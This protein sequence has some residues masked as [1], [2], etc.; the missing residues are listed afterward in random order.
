VAQLILNL[1]KYLSLTFHVINVSANRHVRLY[2]F[3][4]SIFLFLFVFCNNVSF[5]QKIKINSS[6]ISLAEIIATVEQQ[7]DYNF[8]Y[9]PDR[10]PLSEKI[11]LVYP[12]YDIKDLMK[13][14][15]TSLEIDYR[16][17]SRKRI[18]LL[19]K[20][21]LAT[22]EGTANKLFSGIVLDA[23]SGEPLLGA[24]ITNLDR[25]RG[26]NTNEIGLFRYEGLPGED[27][28]MISFIG[29]SHR[30]IGSNQL[31]ESIQ[32]ISLHPN[33]EFEEILIRTPNARKLESEAA[34]NFYLNQNQL[35][36]GFGFL[37]TDP[38]NKVMQLSGIHSGREGQKSIYVRGGSADQNLM[39]MDGV[40]LYETSHVFGLSSIFNINAIK[41]VQVFKHAYPA[42]YGGRLSSIIDFR[43]NEG[44]VFERNSSIGISPI[45][46]HF[47][48]EGPIVKGKS[49]YNLSARKSMV[50]VF[51]QEPIENLLDFD[52]SDFN[53]YDINL[54]L[55][56]EIV[57]GSKISFNYYRGRDNL[58]IFQ[59]DLSNSADM[60]LERNSFDKLRWGNNI[61][62]LN[63]HHNVN[64]RTFSKISIS[65]SDYTYQARSAFQFANQSSQTSEINS[66]D[67]LAN[68]RI[69]DFGANAEFQFFVNNKTELSF[70]TGVYHHR[71]NPTLKQSQIY[72]DGSL[73]EFANSAP[74]I[75]ADEIYV[76]GDGKFALGESTT[77]QTGLRLNTFYVRETNYVSLQPRLTLIQEVNKR[78]KL[79]LS[80][81]KMTQFVHLLVNPGIGLPTEL[82]IPSTDRLP[83]ENAY[84]FAVAYGGFLS[85]NFSFEIGAYIKR[86]ENV[87]EYTSPFDLFYTFLNYS[88]IEI[89]FDTNRDWENFVQ[90]GTSNSRGLE[91]SLSN[92][93]SDNRL[94]FDLSYVLSKTDRQFS[95]FNDG[96]SFPYKYDRTH[97]FSLSASYFITKKL[98]LHGHWVYGTGDAFTLAAEQFRTPDGQLFLNA[99][100]RN[101]FRLDPYHRLDLGIQLS[102]PINGTKLTLDLSV[103]NVYNRHNTYYSYLFENTVEDK[104][105]LE[106][107]S[108]F[109]VMPHFSLNLDF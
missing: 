49:S 39:L 102:Q 7:S 84:Q 13:E 41:N 77:L 16:I 61:A 85:D 17:R 31:K 106:N 109:P 100:G 34:F 33:L 36:E 57:E 74:F 83:P 14:L 96:D 19:G 86:M 10:I 95:G 43:M 90:S 64:Q 2:S 29:Y 101:N 56:H 45:S 15:R 81:T 30:V 91:F 78:Q 23:L 82:W 12:E 22:E 9:S 54:K 89:K 27:S 32:K 38:L 104:F 60:Q 103:F 24:T 51:F 52:D 55:S 93:S 58:E 37:G 1:R 71:F 18:L 3:N 98:N 5:G 8:S 62:S 73:Q 108:L 40:P 72:L 25:S 21:S 75:S 65:A 6:L 80:A 26:V 59:S 11:S 35:N 66:L 4:T 46:A 94:L 69:I 88:N 63:W 76:Y 87:V 47:S 42:K 105:E 44:N 68:S 67:I 70:G 20:S 92:S 99:T 97:D 107:V 53:F 79:T 48:T 50:N 28:I